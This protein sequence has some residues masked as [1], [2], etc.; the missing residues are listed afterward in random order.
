[1]TISKLVGSVTFGLCVCNLDLCCCHPVTFNLTFNLNT[2]M[3]Y[4]L[5]F[6]LFQVLRPSCPFNQHII[7]YIVVYYET[8]A[9]LII[10]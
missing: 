1:M 8:I 6:P 4:K 9:L 3:S 2:F 10:F 5:D 7:A